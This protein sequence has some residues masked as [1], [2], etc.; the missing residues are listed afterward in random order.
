MLIGIGSIRPDSVARLYHTQLRDGVRQ[1]FHALIYRSIGVTME[2]L[3]GQQCR[4]PLTAVYTVRMFQNLREC[5]WIVHH[6]A[7][8]FFND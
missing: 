3:I 5:Q 6:Q 7:V 1:P 8:H 4:N 2:R